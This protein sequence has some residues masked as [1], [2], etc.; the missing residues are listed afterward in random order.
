MILHS[1]H[2]PLLSN[3]EYINKKIN[4]LF[5]F[6]KIL[7]KIKNIE[8]YIPNWIIRENEMNAISSGLII[9]ININILHHLLFLQF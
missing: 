5:I 1:F 9:D 4:I 3:S 2:F 6:S 7:Y 8:C